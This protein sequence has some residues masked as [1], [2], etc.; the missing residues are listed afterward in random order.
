MLNTQKFRLPKKGRNPPTHPQCVSIP[1]RLF[2]V[3]YKEKV[4]LVGNSQQYLT[5][6]TCFQLNVHSTGFVGEIYL[7]Y[8][9]VLYN[10]LKYFKIQ[11]II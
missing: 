11:C 8:I 7:F 10:V 2:L 4:V 9:I 6:Y 1:K 5:G 3:L